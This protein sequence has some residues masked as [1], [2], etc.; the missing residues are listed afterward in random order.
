M[1]TIGPEWTKRRLALELMGRNGSLVECTV[2]DVE[3]L[4]QT[5]AEIYCDSISEV[6]V[7]DENNNVIPGDVLFRKML[8]DAGQGDRSLDDVN[9]L[10][11]E[12]KD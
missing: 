1:I 4:I 2:G 11:L 6:K 3:N 8:L 7:L 9:Q 12:I 10:P 5:F